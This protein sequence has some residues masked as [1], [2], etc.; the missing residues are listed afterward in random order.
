MKWPNWLPPLTTA[1]TTRTLALDAIARVQLLED[2][3]S[4]ALEDLRREASRV[5][6]ANRRAEARDA[7]AGPPGGSNGQQRMTMWEFSRRVNSGT[8]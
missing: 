6:Q 2:R 5:E 8:P 7:S 1:P 4:Q 3:V